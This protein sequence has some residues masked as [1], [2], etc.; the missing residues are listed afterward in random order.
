MALLELRRVEK[1][2]EPD[3]VLRDIDLALDSGEIMCLLGPSGCGK[4]T[5]LRII[6][7]LETTDGG[8]VLFEGADITRVP[9]HRRRFGMMFQEFAL[10]P[11]QNVLENVAFG[12]AVQKRPATEIAIRSREVLRLVGLEGLEQRAVSALSG[13][14]RQRVALARS[15]APYPRLLLLDEPMGSLDRVLRERLVQDL[16]DILKQVHITSLFVTHDHNEAFAVADRIAVLNEGRIEQI[17]T[18][19]DLYRNPVNRFVAGFLGFQNLLSGEIREDGRVQTGLGP[20]H[21]GTVPTSAETAVTVLIRPEAARLLS[22]GETARERETEIKARI[23][24]IRFQGADYQ[25]QLQTG[26]KQTLVLSL[27]GDTL[28]P[29]LGQVLRL[30]LKPSAVSLIGRR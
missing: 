15:L 25:L 5:L 27:P 4:T 26:D 13:G 11:H 14:Q 16:G 20:L 30:A 2:M 10:F 6:A 7:G 1:N 22:S 9:A 8:Q 17:D 21:L 19:V 3:L 29:Q 24:R 28:N 18:P 12:L 23:D